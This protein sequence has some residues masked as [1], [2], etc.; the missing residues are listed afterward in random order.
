MV[1]IGERVTVI[2]SKKYI[3]PIVIQILMVIAVQKMFTPN[4]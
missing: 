2:I 4:I 3:L 1:L